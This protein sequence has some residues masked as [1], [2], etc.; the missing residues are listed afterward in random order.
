MITIV[1]ILFMGLVAISVIQYNSK[2]FEEDVK[3]DITISLLEKTRDRYIEKRNNLYLDDPYIEMSP[4]TRN[5]ITQ[6]F[7]EKI[8]SIDK[9]IKDL[10]NEA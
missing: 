2:Q 10:R 6:Q 8:N 3:K 1:A 5:E 4:K 9:K 7:T